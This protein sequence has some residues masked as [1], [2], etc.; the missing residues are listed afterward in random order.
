[1][2]Q[3]TCF[4]TGQCTSLENHN[5]D[6][7]WFE[8]QLVMVLPRQ[9]ELWALSA[10][11]T[12][13]FK[14]AASRSAPLHWSLLGPIGPAPPMVNVQEAISNDFF[15]AASLPF[16][17]FPWPLIS[18]APLLLVVLTSAQ[19]KIV[20]SQGGPA[21]S[22]FPCALNLPSVTDCW[23]LNSWIFQV[24]V[25]HW[26]IHESDYV[27]RPEWQEFSQDGPDFSRGKSPAKS[28]SGKS[29]VGSLVTFSQASVT[30]VMWFLLLWSHG[31]S[32]GLE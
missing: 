15:S 29:L 9:H 18:Q 28:Q 6:C 32:W 26:H 10:W 4:K 5:E 13:S 23:K 19:F 7:Y 8:F 21:P 24:G 3:C 22:P 1:M 20:I 31:A 12:G 27:V 17:L 25:G 11:A 30:V 16:P 14:M 2:R